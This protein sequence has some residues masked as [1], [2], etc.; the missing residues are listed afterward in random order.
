[1]FSWTIGGKGLVAG[2]NFRAVLDI[3][4]AGVFLLGIPYEN[5]VNGNN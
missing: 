2:S 5:V 3:S 4:V 1:V